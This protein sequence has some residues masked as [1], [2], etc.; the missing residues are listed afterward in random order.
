[1]AEA[2][3]MAEVEGSMAV[4]DSPVVTDLAAVE[5]S[6]VA[7][8][9]QAVDSAG[10]ERFAAVTTDVVAIMGAA[11]TGAATASCSGLA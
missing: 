8:G 6:A 9:S 3:A 7:V 5:R 2:V 10:V 4:A 11:D 1:M